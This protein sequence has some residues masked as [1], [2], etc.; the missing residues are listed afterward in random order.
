MPIRQGQGLRLDGSSRLP[1][2]RAELRREQAAKLLEVDPVAEN[3]QAQDDEL[4]IGQ[5]ERAAAGESLGAP[6]RARNPPR[7]SRT[8]G[9]G[10]HTRERGRLLG[11]S[12]EAGTGVGVGSV[13][14]EL[15]R[16]MSRG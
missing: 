13:A 4:E 8:R 16:V 14:A 11:R 5:I 12:S 6:L 3:A 2:E 9:T 1:P 15:E 7:V 10:A